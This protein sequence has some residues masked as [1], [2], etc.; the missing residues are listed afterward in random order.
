M[1]FCELI[2]GYRPRFLLHTIPGGEAGEAPTILASSANSK[3][4]IGSPTLESGMSELRQSK[5]GQNPIFLTRVLVLQ[6][7]IELTPRA[8]GGENAGERVEE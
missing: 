7:W 2:A 6:A 1:E 8:A 5:C 4:L 3:V